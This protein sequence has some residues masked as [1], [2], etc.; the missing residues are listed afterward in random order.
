MRHFIQAVLTTALVCGGGTAAAQ[1][2]WRAEVAARLP[3]SGA[4]NLRL[5]NAGE[6]D[7]FMRLGWR[8]NGDRIELFDRT[9]MVSSDVYESM[10]AAMTSDD[11]AP[12]D[13]L[14]LWHQDTAI[15]TVETLA[16]PGRATGTRTVLRPMQGVE[17]APLDVELP[18]GV[19]PRAATFVF[20]PFLDLEPGES[21]TYDWYAVLSNSVATVTV[22]A[23]DGGP[24]DTPA[25]RYEETLRL[26][27]RGATPEDQIPLNDIYV[28]GGEVVRIDVVGQDMTFLR[29][30]E[31]E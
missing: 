3:D 21:L 15:L 16:E 6:E 9:M 23:F 7:G 8:R 17:H 24:V 12:L 27:V 1:D 4:L 18:D 19:M 13:T 31:P 29:R 11:F 20:A 30:A 2:D 25:G 10:T 14:I 26:E 5:I 28:T 22:T